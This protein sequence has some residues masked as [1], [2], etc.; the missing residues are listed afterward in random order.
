MKD[1][2]QNIKEEENAIAGCTDCADKW[3]SIAENYK[4][5][6]IQYFMNLDL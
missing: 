3:L 1:S 4:V 5:E 6:D 2:E